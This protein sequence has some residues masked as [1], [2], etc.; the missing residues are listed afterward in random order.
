MDFHLEKL[1]LTFSNYSFAFLYTFATPQF[2]SPWL[3]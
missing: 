3:V 2:V 1:A